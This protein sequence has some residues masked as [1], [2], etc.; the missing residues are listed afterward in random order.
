[1]LHIVQCLVS[2]ATSKSPL[3]ETAKLK[4]SLEEIKRCPSTCVYENEAAP[5]PDPIYSA[6]ELHNA[7]TQI[8]LINLLPS[9]PEDLVKIE[10]FA[11][12]S[13]H[14]QPY[15]ALSYVWGPRDA[16][17]SIEVMAKH[18]RLQ[19]ISM[20]LSLAFVRSKRDESYG[21]MQSV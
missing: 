20:T 11:V 14:T 8:R 15:E 5:A 12:D 4:R 19:Q 13:V 1:V 18:L 3:D 7:K 17:V 10:L 6:V 21:L 2:L 16:D 9:Q